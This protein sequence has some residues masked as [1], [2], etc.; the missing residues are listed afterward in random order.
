[1][2]VTD[3]LVQNETFV[4]H[5]GG[6]SFQDHSRMMGSKS[7]PLR[8]RSATRDGTLRRLCGGGERCSRFVVVLVGIR[9]GNEPTMWCRR[10]LT[11][12]P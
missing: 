10:R 7:R 6:Q 8:I 4:F 2:T 1:M 9:C 11:M 5:D 12:D 3:L